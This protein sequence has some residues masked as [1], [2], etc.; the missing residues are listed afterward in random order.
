MIRLVILLYFCFL[1][2]TVSGAGKA[3]VTAKVYDVIIVG[4]GIAGL[5][6]AYNLKDYDVLLLEM[7]NEVG[8]RASTG[9]YRK[10][11]FSRG[12]EYLGKPEGAL[13]DI[14]NEL[15]LTLREIPAPA[16]IVFHGG[17]FYVGEL[18]KARLL[19]EKSNLGEFNRFARGLLKMYGKYDEIPDI[20]LRGELAR[21]D[22]MTAKQWFDE[23][24]FPQIYHEVYNVASRGL[25]GASLDE[26]SALAVLPEFAYDFESFEGVGDEDELEQELSETESH[27]G[28][29]TFDKGIGEIP[30]ALSRHL[31]DS[32]RTNT[33]VTDIARVG[34]LFE[35]RCVENATKELSFSAEAVIVATPAIV[36]LDIG[37]GVLKDQQRHLL[38][39]VNYAP[40]ATI[41]LFSDSPI[42][43]KG[44]DLSIEDGGIFTDIY[45]ASWVAEHYTPPKDARRDTWVSVICA[46]PKSYRDNS[47]LEL[48]DEE[49]LSK[50][51]GEIDKVLS[52][53]S[54]RV[55]GHE[56]NRF[57]YGFP[58]MTPGSYQR[59]LTL[60]KIDS[61]GLILAGDYL[62][63]PTFE[64][65]AASGY[66][67]AQKAI[68][69]LSD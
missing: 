55:T 25:F 7:K 17:K 30:V 66:L 49:L 68:E 19:I 69:W 63:Y 54:A 52:G 65:A 31:G 32:I 47:V 42:F 3:N 57:K 58:V 27:T 44:F 41:A 45:H 2:C 51:L 26:I 11:S 28:M 34:E 23:N 33:R 9:Q 38:G 22:N 50:V 10:I 15:G 6:A 29:Y 21:M 14:I 48:S 43:D 8:G 59:M 36:A 18:G 20:S 56:I 35:I 40:Y 37:D 12:A 61:E 62:I 5:T 67:A 60:I 13:A 1:P 24:H 39:S 16:D 64:A 4:G 46:A 53:S